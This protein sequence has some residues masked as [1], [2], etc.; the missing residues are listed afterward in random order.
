M[1]LFVLTL[2]GFVEGVTEFLPISSTAHLVLL[3]T[4][5]RLPQTPAL[6]SLEIAIQCGAIAAAVVLERK[7]WLSGNILARI[8]AGFIPTAILGFLFHHAVHALFQSTNLILLSIGLGGVVLILFPFLERRL[9]RPVVRDVE[10]MSLLQACIIGTAQALAII[11]GVSRSAATVL[12]GRLIGMEQVVAVE[13]SFLL[14]V[15]TMLAAT[16]LDILSSI[17]VLTS[18]DYVAILLG[19]LISFF[20]ALGV[21]R[22]FLTFVRTRTLAIFGV[23]RVVFA[24]CVALLL[25][26]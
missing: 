23:Y 14:A 25:M 15:P 26:R 5:L 7:R 21:M 9:A 16:G 12:C 20:V 1:S 10:G 22:W 4:F 24:V 6:V 18:S 8:L 19:S 11:P 17:D 2:F 13:F 3:A